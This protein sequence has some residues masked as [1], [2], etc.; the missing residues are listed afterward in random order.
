M[1]YKLMCQTCGKIYTLPEDKYQT[2]QLKVLWNV[3]LN[4]LGN[5]EV[6]TFM[7]AYAKCC[8]KPN[9]MEIKEMR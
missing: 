2:L 5:V 8:K 6:P 7:N 1:N 9:Y 3:K 4:G